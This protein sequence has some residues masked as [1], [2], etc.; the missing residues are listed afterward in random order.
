MPNRIVSIQRLPGPRRH[1][2]LLHL[3]LSILGA[4]F[5]NR[6]L[7]GYTM[8]VGAKYEIIIDHDGPGSYNNTGTFATSGEII[9]AADIG[10]G[11]FELVSDQTLSSD[12]LNYVLIQLPNQSTSV[13]PQ[14]NALPTARIHWYVTATNAEV[15][16]AVNLAGKSVR[17][18]IR[19]V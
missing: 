14:G 2:R 1:L 18:Q 4:K 19:G 16:N 3:A 13:E 11:G 10:I 17:L 9:N 12:G 6:V 15:A 7:P 8:P 5:A